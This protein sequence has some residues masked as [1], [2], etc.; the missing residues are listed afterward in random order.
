[1][2]DITRREFELSLIGSIAGVGNG[3]SQTSEQAGEGFGSDGYVTD[4]PGVKVGH[5]TDT[6]RPTGCTVVLFEDGATAGVDYDGSG[7]GDWQA[8]MLQPTSM[9]QTIWAIVFAG[10]S[11]YGLATPLGAMRYLAERN[12]GEHWWPG[13]P[14]MVM[15]IVIGAILDDLHV[16][17]WTIRPD[18]ESAYK[19]CQVASPGAVEEGC[20]GAGAGATVG[21]ASFGNSLGMK[22]GVGTASLRVGELVIGALMVVNATGDIVDWPRGHIIAGCRRKDGKGFINL[23]ETLKENMIREGVHRR[24]VKMN[25]TTLGLVATNAFFNKAELTRIAM[26]ANTGAAKVISPYHTPEDGDQLFAVSTR[27]TDLDADVMSVGVLAA[28]V[29]ATAIQRAVKMATS[30]PDYPAYRDYTLKLG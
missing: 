29:V 7:P 9:I 21:T 19:A 10:G 8:V 17:D 30:I 2:S 15:P 20:V 22:S 16:G 11:S 26:M 4:V 3:R 13:R 24:P 12:L 6:R 18:A 5:F 14:R 25:H 28:Q 27:K 1:M 23:A